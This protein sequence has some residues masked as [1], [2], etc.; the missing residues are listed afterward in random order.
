MIARQAQTVIGVV[1]FVDGWRLV[2]R[3]RRWGRFA[4]RSA[5][6]AA[7]WRLTD[8][9]RDLGQDVELVVQERHGEL[10]RLNVG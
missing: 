6:E 10:R 7:A 5:A 9:A 4:R 3:G 8:L 2:S 1:R